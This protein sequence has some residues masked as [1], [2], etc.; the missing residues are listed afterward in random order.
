MTAEAVYSP[1]AEHGFLRDSWL[2]TRGDGEAG[3]RQRRHY[4][5]LGELAVQIE[6]DAA[7][8][9]FQ[10]QTSERAGEVLSSEIPGAY[11]NDY[12]PGLLTPRILKGRP[13]GGFYNRVPIADARPRIFPKVTTSTVVAV[14]SAE[15]AALSSTDFG[16]TAVTATPLMYGAYTDVARQ[17]LDG[18]DP[19]AEAMILQDLYEAYAQASEAVIKTAVEAGSTAS[20]VAIT[21]ATPYAGAIANV[22]N[23]YGTRFKP[24]RGAF[25]PPASFTTL[26]AQADTT[27]R[28]LVPQLGVV[29]SDGQIDGG[30][31]ELAVSLLSARGRL[32]WAST[33]NVWVFG[34]PSDFVIYE[35][36]I[37]RF[38]YDQVAGPQSIRIGIWG[39]LVVGTRLGSLKVTAA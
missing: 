4:D 28:P 1:R 10:P 19:A 9:V 31:D 7:W 27:G 23:Y 25:L 6:R 21:A 17:V 5:Q 32:S 24:A 14:Q 30:G 37:A 3:D 36:S 2:S 29:N 22:V 13:M 11:P 15:G 16:T 8:R 38:S 39:Y 12:L 33:V 18:A 26:T 34:I 35:S 20:G